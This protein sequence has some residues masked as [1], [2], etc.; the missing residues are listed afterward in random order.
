MAKSKKEIKE[1]SEMFGTLTPAERS[2]EL[3]IL[4]FTKEDIAAV[5]AVLAPVSET[6]KAPEV[7]DAPKAPEAKKKNKTVPGG[8]PRYREIQMTKFQG[9]IIDSFVKREGI[10][11]DPERVERLNS[12]SHN[13]L[14]RYELVED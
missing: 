14:I 8:N 1:A 6:P 3:T 12:H 5:E 7:T 9:K 11:L 10:T 13:S 2:E 4:G